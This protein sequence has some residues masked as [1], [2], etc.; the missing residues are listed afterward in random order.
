[1]RR[2]LFY[3]LETPNFFIGWNWVNSRMVT[4]CYI[5]N[6]GLVI[7]VRQNI[8]VLSGPPIEQSFGRHL[9]EVNSSALTLIQQLWVKLVIPWCV[10]CKLPYYLLRHN[11][12]NQKWFEPESLKWSPKWKRRE[13]VLC[14]VN[15][16]SLVPSYYVC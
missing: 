2:Q 8:Y 10:R 13:I 16:Y 14:P 9:R 5:I 12:V 15:Y 1:M 3:T 7:H 4:V 6:A 11:P